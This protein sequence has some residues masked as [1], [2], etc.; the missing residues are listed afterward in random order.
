MKGG[1]VGASGGMSR[2]Y[3]Y[4]I[5]GGARLD[6]RYNAEYK[7]GAGGD[8]HQVVQVVSIDLGGH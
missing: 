7:T 8:A 1:H 3:H 4:E 5:T 6:Y 2:V